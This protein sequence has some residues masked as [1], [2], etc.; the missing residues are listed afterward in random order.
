MCESD[1]MEILLAQD[2]TR[3]WEDIPGVAWIGILMGL[4]FLVIAIRA[5]FGKK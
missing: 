3:P 1:R 5:M 2:G 4:A